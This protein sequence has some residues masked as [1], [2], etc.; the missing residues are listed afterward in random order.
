MVRRATGSAGIAALLLAAACSGSQ[1]AP[2]IP[3]PPAPETRATLAGPLCES[4]GCR[5]KS[6][7]GD[8]AGTP[9]EG[10]KRYEVVLG[11]SEN[12]LWATVD[13]M[14]LYKSRERATECFYVDLR[15]GK[16]AVT[17]RAHEEDHFGARLK[18]AEQGKASLW[19]YDT[20]D[21]YCGAPGLCSLEGLDSWKADAARFEQGK[22]DPCGSTLI[23]GVTWQTGTVP[24]LLHPSELLLELT[25]D[26]YEFVP[27]QPPGHESCAK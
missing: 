11:P 25:L 16:H 2:R 9:A 10:V 20:F 27:E 3:E 21:F 19:W 1:S 18:I 22:H 17:L 15:P 5:C 24:D 7:T 14:V 4:D 13:D 26:V 8:D 23:R 6:A 12:Q